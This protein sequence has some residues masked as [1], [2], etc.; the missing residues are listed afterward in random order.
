MSGYA[1][2]YTDSKV[3]YA[4]LQLNPNNINKFETKK[5]IIIT[6]INPNLIS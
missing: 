1:L 6:I 5:K 3:Y 2:I 4:H